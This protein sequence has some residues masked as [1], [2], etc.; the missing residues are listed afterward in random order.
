GTILVRDINP[1]AGDANPQNLTNVNG[2]LYFSA[3]DGINGYELWK[4]D[5][6]SAGTILVRDINA[7]AGDANPRNLTNVNGTLYFSAVPGETGSANFELWK[8]D[9]TSAGTVLIKD[10]R[11]G[12]NGS[13]PQLLTNVNGTLYFQANDGTNGQELWK[14]DGTSAG[15]VLVKDI[16]VGSLT[17]Y[18]QLLTNVNGI[19]YFQAND[20]A[21]G[22]ELWKSDGS[23]SGTILVKDIRPGASS[24]F[25]KVLTNFNGM[26]YFNANDGINGYELWK[27]DG[28]SSGTVLVKDLYGGSVGSAPQ[29]LT[30][31]NSQLYFVAFEVGQSEEIWTSDGTSTGTQVITTVGDGTDLG[32]I[33]N[34]TASSDTLFFSA[35]DTSHGQ[36]LWKLSETS[37]ANVGP[38]NT[39][40]GAQTVNE[41]AALLISGISI[42][43]VDA[44]TANVTVTLS[45]AS[46]TLNIITNAGGGVT[47]GDISGNGSVTVTITGSQSAINATLADA[48]GVSYLGN[49]NFNGSDVLTVTTNDL[50]NA[51]PGGAMTDTDTVSITVNA[52]NDGPTNTVPGEQTANEDVALLITGL[53]ISDIDAG[54]ANVTVTL[55]VV[56]GTLTII[57]NAGGGVTSGDVSGNGSGTVTITG[58][59]SAINATLADASGLIYQGTLN[60]NGGDELTV[61]TNDLG[62]TGAPGAL[63]DTDTIAIT[64]NAVNDVPTGVNDSLT[65]I[66]EDS[67]NR[68]IPIASLVANDSTGPSNESGQSLT[69]ISVGSPVGGAVQIV[70]N[71]VIF[72]PTLDFSGPASFQY[73]VRDNGQTNGVDD[74]KTATATASFTIT[75]IVD[76]TFS[77]A[78]ATQSTAGEAGSYQVIAVA[79][80]PLEVNLTVPLLIGGDAVHPADYTLSGTSLFFPIG[81][82]SAA[83]TLTVAPDMLDEADDT[84]S[85]GLDVPTGFGTVGSPATHTLTIVDDDTAA[86]SFAVASQSVNEAGGSVSVLVTLSVPSV[87]TITIPF[88]VGGSAGGADFS[89]VTASPLSI[90][91]GQTSGTIVVSISN[92]PRDEANETI[93]LTLGTPT[94]A[95]LGT[96]AT[97]T[98]TILDNDPAPLVQ[99]TSLGQSV[100]ESA[101]TGRVIARL[102]QVSGLD[103]TVPVTVGG[104]AGAGDATVTTTLPITILAGQTSAAIDVTLVDDALAESTET[105]IFTI[106]TPTN[107]TLGAVSSHTLSI[108]D[109]DALVQVQFETGSFSVGEA[110]GSLPVFV[111]LSSIAPTDVTVSLTLS[112]S[113]TSSDYVLS[114]STLTIPAGQ[115]RAT[116]TVAI[117]DDVVDEV[118]ETLVINLDTPTGASLGA[119][120]ALTITIDD[121]DPV[122]SFARSSDTSANENGTITVVA[123]TLSPVIADLTVPFT[124]FG[125]AILNSDYTLSANQF[126]FLAGSSTA[127]VTIT[128]TDD[129]TLEPSE[130]VTLQLQPPPNT[131]LGSP[132]LYTLFISDNDSPVAPGLD[133]NGFASGQDFLIPAGEFVEDGAAVVLMPNATVSPPGVQTLSSLIV[134]LE[135]APN[136]AAESLTAVNFGG[137]TASA[138]NTATRTITISGGSTSDMQTVLRSVAYQNTSQNPTAGGR[139]VSVTANFSASVDTRRRKLNVT[140]VDDA[141]VVGVG[142]GST[143]YVT[144]NSAMAIAPAATLTDIENNRIVQA[145]VTL[146]DAEAGDVLSFT[147]TAGFTGVVTGN[148]VTITANSGSGN[149][150]AFRTA[151][152]R[153]NFVTTTVGDGSRTVSFVVTDTSGITGVAGA[154]SVPVNRTITV[155]SP[156][157]IADSPLNTAA[158]NE[159]L[160]AAQLQPLVTEA[161]AR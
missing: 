20:G 108:A 141:P 71:N 55:S 147:S 42:L 161:I 91:A 11:P 140:P 80:S 124:A 136:G 28:S 22:Y 35:F 137:A 38:T 129:A 133:L 52:V 113:A 18:P 10:I 14:S 76:P 15:T 59:Q 87:A 109:N 139:F 98:L 68:A 31:W 105:L 73:T 61:L 135:S 121:N 81:A 100:V 6:T 3:S 134:Y 120:A 126:Q 155:Q 132:G 146:T 99:F 115:T 67:G 23:S 111:T 51:G 149:V 64:V 48:S 102:S 145:V 19:L 152:T 54:T 47:S 16:R 34:L 69:V 128:I 156:L 2:T 50:G 60:F 27:S 160:T 153:V 56:S 43:D 13:V 88:T 40:L 46:G 12:N 97:H 125:A 65:A 117:T 85:F 78:L 138:Y 92:D 154:S 1:G 39:V 62:N 9:G 114:T 70:D 130:T 82:T 123:R 94:N 30:V 37:A 63:T 53:S 29:S 25:P 7:G 90:P 107:G 79:S 95:V 5:G 106:G 148:V 116:F 77:F 89:V 104:S 58:S 158:T 86:A 96:V 151:L 101:A 44:G 118:A 21:N 36:E 143:I 131:S 75:D 41:D 72:T 119:N 4:S 24:A 8:S 57:T 144:G 150:T 112:G 127:A 103:V 83:I 33:S 122:L 66:T 84:V 157:L 17:A 110:I 32:R 45:V 159:Q 142:G 74:F 49:M 26:L 93:S